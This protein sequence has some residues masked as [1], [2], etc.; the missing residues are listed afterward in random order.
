MKKPARSRKWRRGK[1][2]LEFVLVMGSADNSDRREWVFDSGASR[3]QL[4]DA[5]V[6]IE[7]R[8]CKDNIDMADG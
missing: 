8:A 7:S 3:H 5:Q 6:L 1:K 2:T 4:S